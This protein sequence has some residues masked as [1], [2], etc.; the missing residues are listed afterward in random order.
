VIDEV[1]HFVKCPKCGHSEQRHFNAIEHP[2]GHMRCTDLQ[3]K[4]GI[5]HFW[6]IEGCECMLNRE[7]IHL[8]LSK[9]AEATHARR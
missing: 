4:Q 7:E 5:D 3:E 1:D 6:Y 2:G 8:N 9:R